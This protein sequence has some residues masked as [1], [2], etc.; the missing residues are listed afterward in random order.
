MADFFQQMLE[1]VGARKKE[2][3]SRA[4]KY[5]ESSRKRLLTILKKKLQTSFIGPL[6]QFENYFGELWG[7][8]K[9]P[10]ERTPEEQKWF[11]TWEMVRTE[12]LNNGNNQLRAVQSELLQYTMVWDGHKAVFTTKGN[13]D[14]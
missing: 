11:E 9:D 2:E 7:H 12:V 1:V 8:G 3:V 5:A 6:S 4:E 10:S 14:E 13:E